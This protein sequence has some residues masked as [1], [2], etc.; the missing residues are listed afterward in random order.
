MSHCCGEKC[1][2]CGGEIKS[3]IEGKCDDC[4]EDK[5]LMKCSGC[6][7]EFHEHHGC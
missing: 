6:H 3:E 5:H 1:L 4:G 2:T 7:A